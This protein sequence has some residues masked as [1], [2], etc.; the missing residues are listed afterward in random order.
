MSKAK[1]DTRDGE[2]RERVRLPVYL[3]RERKAQLRIR[4]IEEGTT[5]SALVERLIED[6]LLKRRGER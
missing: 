3:T 5:A 6:Y 1:R 2:R 4:A